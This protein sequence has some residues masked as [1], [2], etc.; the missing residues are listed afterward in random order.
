MVVL[1]IYFFYPGG[2]DTAEIEAVFNDI[3]ESA[4]RKDQNGITEY[5]SLHYK[6]EYGATYPAVKNI[7]KKAFEKFDSFDISYSDLSVSINEN[8]DGEKEAAANLDA[9]VTGTKSGVPHSLIGS[10]ESSEN[11]TVI[12]RKSALGGWK[13]IEVQ[14]LDSADHGY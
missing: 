13:I 5:F 14:G 7:I 2:D 1:L 12:L 11:V 6:D 8:A 10:D 4:E 3:I 9:I